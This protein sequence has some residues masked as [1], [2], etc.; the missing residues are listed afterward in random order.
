MATNDYHFVTTWRIAASPDEISSVLGD[1][2]GLAR[3]W[4]SV[5]ENLLGNADKY[6]PPGRPIL[7]RVWEVG[8]EALVAIRDR[9]MGFGATSPE[10]LFEPIYRSPEARSTASGLGIGLA[11]CQRI[12]Q[13][14]GGRIWAKP[15][16]G[17]G[18][19]VGFALPIPAAILDPI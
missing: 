10:A 2:A 16:N 19:E 17:G 5:V 1:A 15:R 14:L 18:A 3:W 6:S 13:A 9:G 4:P 7:I 11:L 8:D 12:V